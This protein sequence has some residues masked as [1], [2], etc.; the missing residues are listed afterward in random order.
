MSEPVTPKET[1]SRLEPMKKV[2]NRSK[3]TIAIVATVVA[4]F[5]VASAKHDNDVK[6][7]YQDYLRENDLTKHFEAWAGIPYEESMEFIYGTNP[8]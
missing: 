6:H 8:E 4:A 3:G 2:W 1:K 7:W 5:A